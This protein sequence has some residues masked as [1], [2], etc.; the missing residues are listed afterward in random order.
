MRLQKD[1]DPERRER[2]RF[3][4]SAHHPT[5][6]FMAFQPSKHWLWTCSLRM[7]KAMEELKPTWSDC[8]CTPPPLLFTNHSSNHFILLLSQEKNKTNKNRLNI[9]LPAQ[10]KFPPEKAEIRTF[11]ASP[12]SLGSRTCRTEANKAS[13]YSNRVH[14][15]FS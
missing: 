4:C 9:L 11:T 6:S 2:A 8:A 10:Q 12:G 13:R 3:H 7:T 1:V 14:L 15:T 5:E